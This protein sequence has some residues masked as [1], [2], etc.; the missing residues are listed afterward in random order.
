MLRNVVNEPQKM[1]ELVV[2]IWR[3]KQGQQHF[4]QAEIVKYKF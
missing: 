4:G 2:P 3:L 1:L